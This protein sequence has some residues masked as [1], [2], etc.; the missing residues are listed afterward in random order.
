M[1]EQIKDVAGADALVQSKTTGNIEET[2]DLQICKS[3]T[4]TADAN[5]ATEISAPAQD[6]AE[7]AANP[8]EIAGADA[9]AALDAPDVLPMRDRLKWAIQKVLTRKYDAAY[10]SEVVD[11]IRECSRLAMDAL[12]RGHDGQVPPLIERLLRE[13][14][15]VACK[16]APQPPTQRELWQKR[17]RGTR[18]GVGPE[19]R[20]C[21]YVDEELEVL[22]RTLRPREQIEAFDIFGVKTNFRTITREDLRIGA[23]APYLTR[24]PDW[25]R[26]SYLNRFRPLL[27]TPAEW[28]AWQDKETE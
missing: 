18:F 19:G 12:R 9:L 6:A 22:W 11:K 28:R 21:N 15:I 14:F 2:I 5:A 8:I 4:E 24:L 13:T 20:P 25:D 23:V 17:I 26:Q 1:V 27:P 10:Q 3:T 16:N 7:A